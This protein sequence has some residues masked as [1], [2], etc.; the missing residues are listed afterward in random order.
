[1]KTCPGMADNLTNSIMNAISFLLHSFCDMIYHGFETMF[2]GI[3][4]HKN[5]LDFF[6]K[7][8]VIL[9][10][11]ST[12]TGVLGEVE[13][14]TNVCNQ[15]IPLASTISG[16]SNGLSQQWQNKIA[17]SDEIFTYMQ[18]SSTPNIH[19]L[20]Q[21]DDTESIASA[22]ASVP[23]VTSFPAASKFKEYF[24]KNILIALDGIGMTTN[25][26]TG[27]IP[28]SASSIS[29]TDGTVATAN[30]DTPPTIKPIN[31]SDVMEYAP[32]ITLLSES[33]QKII[34][35]EKETHVSMVSNWL[36]TIL[37][38]WSNAKQIQLELDNRLE[39]EREKVKK[40]LEMKLITIGKELSKMISIN[41]K[42]LETIKL[43]E[44]KVLDGEQSER[45][46]KA[47]EEKLHSIKN[48][49]NALNNSYNI[50]ENEKQEL[51]SQLHIQ[52]NQIHVL[53]GDM[54]GLQ[55]NM[56][57]LQTNLQRE[58]LD[59]EQLQ[60]TI[61]TL[62]I[63]REELVTERDLLITKEFNRTQRLTTIGIQMDY[64]FNAKS[65]EI[66]TE[67]LTPPVSILY[68]RCIV[69]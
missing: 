23:S 55:Q 60:Q 48:E 52:T 26:T 59:K 9:Q 33:I 10:E 27:V 56:T 3:I 25:G 68:I 24:E 20:Q 19:R 61:Q 50:I 28:S 42:N 69:M 34:H 13:Q 54:I 53:E 39:H 18:L 43:L 62:L 21:Q 65:I 38:D 12:V 37:Q 8:F 30:T 32:R 22:A 7:F 66:Q 51:I 2:D 1:M 11:M 6:E 57:S 31:N 41:E 58:I 4:S 64:N 35:Y 17:L 63:Q 15:I 16:N 46:F 36:S 40:P 44:R 29:T 45:S 47:T 67:F 14:L 5:T 49:L